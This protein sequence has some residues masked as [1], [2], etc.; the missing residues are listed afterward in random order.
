MKP[1]LE[2]AGLGRILLEDEERPV[3]TDAETVR[4]DLSRQRGEG[5]RALLCMLR[6]GARHDVGPQFGGDA[7]WTP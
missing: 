5:K 7:R 1:G 3:Y 2:G 4:P 6:P